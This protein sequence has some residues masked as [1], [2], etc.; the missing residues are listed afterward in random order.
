MPC[1]FELAG[2]I[3]YRIWSI[4]FIAF[5]ISC[6]A[7]HADE[8]QALQEVK[9]FKTELW[10]AAKAG[11]ITGAGREALLAR[12]HFAVGPVS[13]QPG[14]LPELLQAWPSSKH[15]IKADVPGEDH[16]HTEQSAFEPRMLQ[17]ER[18]IL[19]S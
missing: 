15:V 11:N 4:I 10:A 18:C 12:L 16:L 14:W 5:Q 13:K 8:Y 2:S 1:S 9:Q 19:I 6:W 7:C 3:T 17:L